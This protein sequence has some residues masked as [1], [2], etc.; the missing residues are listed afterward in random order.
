MT[1][2]GS[3]PEA[4]FFQMVGQ[5]LSWNSQMARRGAHIPTP[6]SLV[7]RC[8]EGLQIAPPV[9]IFEQSLILFRPS[10]GLN[11]S[12][13]GGRGDFL[14]SRRRNGLAEPGR[15]ISGPDLIP[16]AERHRG[17]ER[18]FELADISRPGEGPKRI[19]SRRRKAQRVLPFLLAGGFVQEMD[20]QE[21]NVF[22]PLAQGW[23]FDFNAAEA[24]LE[25]FPKLFFPHQLQQIFV[26]GGDNPR[27]GGHRTNTHEP[28]CP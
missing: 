15:E 24:I 3:L 2:R 9:F 10:W 1:C 17:Q 4:Q 18:L 21:R 12:V 16:L 27:I 6:G 13:C 7:F 5:G 28:N 8:L 20:R 19:Q 14:F 11:L 26:G 25:V 23:H 22:N